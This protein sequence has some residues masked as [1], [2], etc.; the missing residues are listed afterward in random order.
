ME[1]IDKTFREAVADGRIHGAVLLAKD[2][3]G[4]TT[5]PLI[6]SEGVSN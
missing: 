2:L 3:T 6:T 1:E 4:E 5:N